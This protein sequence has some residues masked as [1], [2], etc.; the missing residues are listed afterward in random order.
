MKPYYERDGIQIF[1]GDCRD[2]LPALGA[3]S[4]DAIVT[5]P[6]YG[7]A[8]MGKAWDHGVPGVPFWNEALP[9]LKPGGHLLAA[10]GTRTHHRLMVAIEDAGFDIRDCLMWL[11]GS[12]F[13]KGKGQLKPAWE[14]IILA[15]K[16][17]PSPWLNIDGC[18]VGSDTSRGDRYNGKAPGGGKGKFFFS[19]AEGE[20]GVNKPWQTPTG[21]WPANVVLSHEP[22]C[23]PVKVEAYRTSDEYDPKRGYPLGVKE[24]GGCVEW[25]VAALL[26]A[27]SG[28]RGP[29]LGIKP[30]WK[31]AD[32]KNA[33]WKR[34]AHETYEPYAAGYNDTGGASR[35]F[36]AAKASRSERGTYNDHPTVKPLALM[37][38]LVRLVTP[39]GG[40]VLDPFMGS[41][42]TLLASAREGFDC[43][44]IELS[45]EYCEI[46]AKRLEQMV[47]PLEA[48]S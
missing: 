34:K 26:D 25:C 32:S 45:E 22:E 8:F 31:G 20:A 36:Y 2:V 39:P 47:L 40:V 4:A 35:F 48:V 17:A 37:R 27:Q 7:L 10:G 24:T 9:I 44:G 6:P 1:H 43:I 42:T 11:Y 13:P 19:N 12:G 16:R 14:P 30:G 3:G 21:R 18:R 33:G 23:S 5:D 15:R 29:S 46:A 28:E 41:G 38:W